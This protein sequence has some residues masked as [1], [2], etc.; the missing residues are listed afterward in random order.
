MSGDDVDNLIYVKLWMS[1]FH[2]VGESVRNSVY[3]TVKNS[4][5]DQL[6]YDVHE[7]SYAYAWSDRTAV[8]AL[9]YYVYEHE[10]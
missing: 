4:V 5:P 8:Q 7:A 2:Y 6:Y 10:W 1:V 3:A 9:D